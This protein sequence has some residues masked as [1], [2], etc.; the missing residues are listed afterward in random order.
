MYILLQTEGLCENLCLLLDGSP[1][2]LRRVLDFPEAQTN[3]SAQLRS[4]LVQQRIRK[5][6]RLTRVAWNR[7]DDVRA[8]EA[9]MCADR[10]RHLRSDLSQALAILGSGIPLEEAHCRVLLA[11]GLLEVSI[12][13]VYGGEF[14]TELRV[15]AS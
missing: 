12:D 14:G 4:Y 13:G 1:L 6:E 8:G 15:Q 11:C 5:M 2:E 3:S 10:S 9:R 7:R